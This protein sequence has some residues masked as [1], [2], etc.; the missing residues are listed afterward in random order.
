MCTTWPSF[1]LIVVCCLLLPRKNKQFHASVINKNCSGRFLSAYFLFSE[2]LN[3]NLTFAVNVILN[4]SN[5]I[6]S[7]SVSLPRTY[8]RE[9]WLPSAPLRLMAELP[10]TS[11]RVRKSAGNRPVVRQAQS[12]ALGVS[13]RLRYSQPDGWAH[14][15]KGRVSLF[16]KIQI[17]ISESK[18][19]I[20]FFWANPK[21][22][23]ESI[24][25]TLWVDSSDQIQI[26]IF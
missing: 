9:D 21:T 7:R 11:S 1:S 25:S 16:G 4:L 19:G 12:P 18:N 5:I 17:W 3:L 8:V 6:S 10:H 26:R 23:H 22:G 15:L 20:C 24:K 14:G 13:M 2:I